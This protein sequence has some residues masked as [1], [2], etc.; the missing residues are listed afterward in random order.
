MLI[1]IQLI[2]QPHEALDPATPKDPKTGKILY[3]NTYY[4]EAWQAM[5]D[6]QDAG[7]AR[8]TG[9]SN[10]NHKMAA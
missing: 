9:A 4:T 7:L 8:S 2:G 1:F 5:G 10:F 6:C 3:S